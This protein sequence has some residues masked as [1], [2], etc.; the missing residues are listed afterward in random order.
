MPDNSFYDGG[1]GVHLEK[2]YL[3]KD[4][5]IVVMDEYNY[6]LLDKYSYGLDREYPRYCPDFDL[7]ELTEIINRTLDDLYLSF[8]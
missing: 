4:L 5:D 2:K 7:Q 3:E 6:Q 8:N 1:V